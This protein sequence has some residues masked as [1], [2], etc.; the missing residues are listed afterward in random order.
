MI[1]TQGSFVAGF[2]VF[3]VLLVVLVVFVIKFVRKIGRR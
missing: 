2:S 3:I 1:A